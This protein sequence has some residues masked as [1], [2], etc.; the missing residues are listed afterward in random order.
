[1]VCCSRR[2][3]SVLLQDADGALLSWSANTEELNI[4]AKARQCRNVLQ[5]KGALYMENSTSKISENLHFCSNEGRNESNL[6]L[7]G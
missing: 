4:T 6:V 7:V 2:L 5:E 1:M 3:N